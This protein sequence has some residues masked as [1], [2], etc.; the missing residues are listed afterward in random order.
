MQAPI[1]LRRF[2]IHKKKKIRPTIR[3]ISARSG[4]KSLASVRIQGEN[5]RRGLCLRKPP[6]SAIIRARFQACWSWR[7]TVTGP[8]TYILPALSPSRRKAPLRGACP[9]PHKYTSSSKLPLCWLRLLVGPSLG[10]PLQGRC[11]QRSN[12]FLTDLLPQSLTDV[13]SWGFAALPPRCNLN[14]FVYCIATI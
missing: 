11:K 12:L 14:D 2:L 9:L 7:Q 6:T 3:T 10:H 5:P 4:Q 1:F 8:R 13:S